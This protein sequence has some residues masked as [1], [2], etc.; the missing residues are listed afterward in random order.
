MNNENQF[1]I[2]SDVS[3]VQKDDVETTS[4]FIN[5][6]KKDVHSA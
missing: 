4:L 3:S 6:S 5:F 2:R 1:G